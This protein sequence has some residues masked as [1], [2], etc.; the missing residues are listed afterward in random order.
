MSM[1]TGLMRRLTSMGVKARLKTLELKVDQLMA[2]VPFPREGSVKDRTPASLDGLLTSQ[3]T[4]STGVSL[5]AILANALWEIGGTR[6]DDG[7]YS[8]AD[9]ALDVIK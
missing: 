3:V 5:E 6:Y 9:D 4:T 1:R 8:V 2:T 7:D